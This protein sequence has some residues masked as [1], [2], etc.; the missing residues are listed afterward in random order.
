[1][2]TTKEFV[3]TGSAIAEEMKLE[4][5]GSLVA[6][7]ELRNQLDELERLLT[8]EEYERA[9]LLGY[10]EIAVGF[11]DLQRCLGGVQALTMDEQ[12]LVGEVSRSRGCSEEEA[13]FFLRSQRQI[14][15]QGHD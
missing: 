9:S 1:M 15:E 5:S 3:E 2:S 14:A 13:R 8:G 4:V 12:L 10:Q 6:I 7:G 11:V